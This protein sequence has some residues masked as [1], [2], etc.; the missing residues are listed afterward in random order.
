MSP[1]PVFWEG[2]SHPA[3]EAGFGWAAI[4]SNAL[5]SRKAWTFDQSTGAL[6]DNQNMPAMQPLF[7]FLTVCAGLFS[8]PLHNAVE[9]AVTDLLSANYSTLWIILL[10]RKSSY[11]PGLTKI[12]AHLPSIVSYC[13]EHKDVLYVERPSVLQQIHRCS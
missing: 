1:V 2:L 10:D 7:R 9:T 4:L 11:A 12:S 6:S 5:N 3:S 13:L 8:N